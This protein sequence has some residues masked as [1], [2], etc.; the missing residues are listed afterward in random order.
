[1]GVGGEA[2]ERGTGVEGEGCS[3]QLTWCCGGPLH[4]DVGA[5]VEAAHADSADDNAAHDDTEPNAPLHACPG[6]VTG[7]QDQH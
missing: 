5:A 6:N 1:M 2:G 4:A 7:V 3:G